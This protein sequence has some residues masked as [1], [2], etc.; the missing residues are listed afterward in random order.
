MGCNGTI[1]VDLTRGGDYAL[2]DYR[3][4]ARRLLAKAMDERGE[5]FGPTTIPDAAVAMIRFAAAI[6]AL[7]Q[8]I[9]T[10]LAKEGR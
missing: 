4:Q 9:R 2:A 6:R 7:P 5:L 10:A 8:E 3:R 1:T